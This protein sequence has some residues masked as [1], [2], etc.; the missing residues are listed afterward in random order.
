MYQSDPN[1]APVSAPAMAI[2]N[3]HPI[4]GNYN[5]S[6][7]GRIL[8]LLAG[9][10]LFTLLIIS[11]GVSSFVTQTEQVAWRGRQGEAARNAADSVL[12]FLQRA[13]ETITLIGYF[14]PAELQANPHQFFQTLED[15]PAILEVV[16]LDASGTL[17]ASAHQDSAVLADLFTIP[18]SNWFRQA[19]A[20]SEYLGDIQL[21]LDNEPY[22]ILA[23]PAHNGDVI[24]AR[25][26]MQVLGDV[27]AA[28]RFGETGQAYV[29]NR[30]GQV[31]AHTNPQVV[32]ANTS[33][34]T[35]A[36]LSQ[37]LLNT[38]KQWHGMYINFVNLP[39]VGTTVPV[40][41]TDWAVITELAQ[42]EAYA[43]SQRAWWLLGGGM[44]LFGVLV[45]GATVQFMGRLIFQPMGR[46]QAG[47]ERIGQ[48]DLGYRIVITRH[49][50]MGQVATAFNAM[51]S[52]LHNREEQLV[53]RTEALATEVLERKK[54]EDALQRA[55]DELDV[56]VQ[57]RTAELAHA[58]SVLR[59]EISERVRAES[60]LRDSTTR[61]RLI[62]DALPALIAYVDAEQQYSFVNKRYEEW[63]GLPRPEIEGKHLQQVV[64]AQSYAKIQSYVQAALTG[65]EVLFEFTATYPDG[66]IRHVQSAY[67]PHLGM[68][69]QVFGFF[70][71]VQDLTD[72]KQIERDLQVSLEEKVVLLQ[73]IH[74]RVKNNL[75]VISSLLYLQAGKLQDPQMLDILRDSQNRVKSMALIHEKLYQ[76]K[77]LARIDLAIYIHNL[78]NYL[79]RSYAANLDLI[80][81]HV[82][83]DQIFLG[84][85]TAMPCGLIINELVSNALKHAFLADQ[86]GEIQ[87]KLYQTPE[88]RF[89]L[90]IADNGVGFPAHIDFQN[91]SSLGLQLVNTLV[92]QLDGVI[93]LQREGGTTFTIQFAEM[94]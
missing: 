66:H 22:V 49:D 61:I 27:L 7:R 9:I 44:L 89:T 17:L 23:V 67:I 12:T 5:Q 39:V 56:R 81:L 65:Q 78:T 47:A 84:I 88:R 31:I 75:Q 32:A 87:I 85:D 38:D 45:V 94:K 50:E 2:A 21:S 10:L 37:L 8:S 59:T 29:V 16:Y 60:A 34:S 69:G 63:Y 20:G 57:Q 86:S 33:L 77:D 92:D 4:P 14:G 11:V 72:H 93:E 46:L 36:G 91:T 62:T 43:V 74:H 51:A 55:H 28:L 3:N 42:S 1:E 71:L 83:A 24:A 73:E 26:H 52:R 13:K 82:Q 54:A 58:N 19:H 64:G 18:Q 76:T 41:G 70:A 48:G 53:A 68:A 40:S 6:L 15:N 79:F 80:R 30:T 90:S 35:D 25:L